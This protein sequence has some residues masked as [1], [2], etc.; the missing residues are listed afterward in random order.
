MAVAGG[1]GAADGRGG[2]G[3]N[4]T[5]EQDMALWA[6]MHAPELRDPRGYIIP[7]DQ[8]DFPTATKFVNALLETGITVQAR[9]ARLR[10]RGQAVSGRLVRRAPR[11]RRF[12]R[13]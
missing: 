10:R 12:A 8:A 6:A 1:V 5:A 9:D 13:T 7:S 4:A 11:R 3:G 2:R